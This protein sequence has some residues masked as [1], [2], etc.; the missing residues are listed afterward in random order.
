MKVSERLQQGLWAFVVVLSLLVTQSQ[1]VVGQVEFSIGD[2][3]GQFV[4]TAEQAETSP[5]PQQQTTSSLV[6][7]Q[8]ALLK[9]RQ[10]LAH[11][12]V[13]TAQAMLDVAKRQN[14]DFSQIGDS[15]STVQ[16]MIE[17]QFQLTELA[18]QKDRS[19]NSGAA[20]FLLM[21]AEALVQYEDFETAE[22][23]ISQ[24]KKFPVQF[25]PTIGNPDQLTEIIK[26]ARN[27]A[28]LAQQA[29]ANQVQRQAAPVVEQSKKPEVMKLLS[30]TQL[31][32]DQGNWNQA[33]FYVDQAIALKVP[34]S[35]FAADEARPW[36][37]ELKIQ[38]ALNRKLAPPVVPAAFEQPKV[39]QS[40]K[41][42]K[43][44]RVVQA[45]Y[46]PSNDN[47]YNTTVSGSSQ[48]QSPN[49][50][51]P[52]L[53][54]AREFYRLGLKA[55]D[56]KDSRQARM[57]MERAWEHRNQLDD[58]TQQAVQD[59][60]TRL[61][62]SQ[63]VGSRALGGTGVK[64]NLS[65]Q[66]QEAILVSATE[67]DDTRFLEQAE[68]REL[69]S[70]V[71]RERAE[72]ERL[73]KSSPREA[74]EKMT[75]I[76]SRIAQSNLEPSSQRP[77]LNIIDRDLDSMQEY[78]DEN[79]AEIANDESNAE[80]RA[81][82]E[83]RR[84][85]RYDVENQIQKLVEEFN[86]LIDQ[87]RYAEAQ[88]VA[89]QAADLDPDSVAVTLLR[90]KARF[91]SRLAIMEGIR[92]RKE[93][94]VWGGLAAAEE[95]AIFTNWD[96][97]VSIDDP[98]EFRE[99]GL[100]RRARQ[101][102]LRGGS[103]ADRRIWNILRNERVQGEYSGT[104][105]EAID[106]LSTQAGVNI[107]FDD[108][109]L[110]TEN[111]RKDQLVDMPIR[112]PISLRSALQLI[113]QSAGLVF[114]VENESIK[115]TSADS[116]Q[117][118]LKTETY[119]IGDLVMPIVA[120]QHPMHMT[121]MQPNGF[122]GGSG[123]G[124]GVL[125]V[126]NGAGPTNQLAMAQQLGGGLPG[127]PF[128]GA[129]GYNNGPQ[130][131]QPT[132]GTVGGQPFGGITLQDF[133]PLID[134]VQSTIAPD[135]W[136]D[137]GQGLGTVEAFVPNLSLIVSQ[138][139]EIQDQIQDL[140]AKL[141]ELNDVQIV[142]EVRF[143]TLAENFFERIG[144]DFDFNIAS[145]ADPT[146][147]DSQI[148][149]NVSDDV[150]GNGSV[151]L[152]FL[153]E[154]FTAAEPIFGGF[155]GATAANFGFAILSDIEVFFLIQAGKGNNRTS[156]SQAPTVTMFNGQSANVNDGSS[157]PFV[158]SVIPV[159]G[160][161]AVSHQPVITILPEGTNLNVTAVV[162]DDRRFVRLQLVP[163]FSQVTEVNTF[164]FDGSVTTEQTSGSVLD[165]LLDIVDGG[166]NADLD[167]EELTTTTQGITI[168]LPVLS[169]TTISTVVSVPD[170][171]TVLLGGVKR[172]NESRN[173]TGVP[174]LS[175]LPYVN[176]LFKNTGIG[177]ETSNLMMMVTPRIIIQSEIEEDQVGGASLN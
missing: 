71:F 10:A 9:A 3:G 20:S 117:T 147:T 109:A 94:G 62:M 13:D 54:N 70:E 128:A 148:V 104:L 4:P 7:A 47:T 149:A 43:T 53:A 173:E 73:L 84:Q 155:E 37:Y 175:N 135:S 40:V 68:F 65:D 157:T 29:A 52:V 69:Q 17:R 57:Y 98:D 42:T 34:D 76:R 2:T 61:T 19:Y 139:Q 59:Q 111:V 92:D 103:E 140:L 144:I 127:N 60:L 108:L 177:H 50:Y 35:Q 38:N 112:N 1:V 113:I 32:M 176:R 142:V 158:T 105:A 33:K 46:D 174:F 165:D 21:Q 120:P 58:R 78:I 22:M 48:R 23:L 126:A 30:Q 87:Q 119:Y 36:Q 74:L 122:G 97:P 145:N 114:V 5:A 18:N 156:I 100:L 28:A 93:E 166:V 107:V 101:E 125:N 152:Q 25:N 56:D 16:S 131:G 82:V 80:A 154:S 66:G 121:F 86:V 89:R 134:L 85:R 150:I 161:F 132:F 14:I 102:E 138:T 137:T 159:V 136:Q 141:R 118:K 8:R 27:N 15:A 129:G 171:G 88:V 79:L 143:I 169:F 96:H 99:R 133:Q 51:S 115:I 11:S 77:L 153:Q 130:V 163:F 24:A 160:D 39:D 146:I 26:V 110:A 91:V 67:T 168:Q 41:A 45:D 170:G 6:E 172:M 81:T 90:E 49:Q 31:A 162:S 123:G 12:D 95:A 151:D 64:T 106:Q 83:Q 72:T 124:G 75:M 116:Q 44:N 167:D 63:P 55:I 164:T